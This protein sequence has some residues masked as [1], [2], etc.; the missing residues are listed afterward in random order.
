MLT[1]V[2]KID[3]DHTPDY[4]IITHEIADMKIYFLGIRI[5]RKKWDVK[6]TNGT[7]PIPKRKIG[8]TQKTNEKS[9]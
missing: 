2:T 6:N 8:L 3:R 9:T 7:E 1:K 5:F 4:D